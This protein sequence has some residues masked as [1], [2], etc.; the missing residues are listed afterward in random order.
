[1]YLQKEVQGQMRIKA[2]SDLVQ[3]NENSGVREIVRGQEINWFDRKA[4]ECGWRQEQAWD[5]G[6][7]LGTNGGGGGVRGVAEQH[8]K[9]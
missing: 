2:K 9:Y 5:T 8:C 1:M 4:Y 3:M 7:A 6:Q